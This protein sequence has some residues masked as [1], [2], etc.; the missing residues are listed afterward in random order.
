MEPRSVESQPH[1]NFYVIF[2]GIIKAGE[3]EMVLQ[4]AESATSAG[5]P[6]VNRPLCHFER[7]ILAG[8]VSGFL[9][10]DTTCEETKCWG[11]GDTFCEFLVKVT[12]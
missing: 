7:G 6:D 9:G 10:K 11:L 8:A 3:N 12:G 2:Q 4:I 5:M 1:R